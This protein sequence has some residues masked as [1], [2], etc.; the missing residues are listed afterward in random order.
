MC[1]FAQLQLCVNALC[2]IR[3]ALYMETSGFIIAKRK[4]TCA[5]RGEL[6]DDEK[7]K[8]D[9]IGVDVS[10]FDSGQIKTLENLKFSMNISHYATES[11]I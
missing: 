6:V 9:V 8:I 7:S 2:S 10:T 4:Q 3:F 11:V 1:E 5:F